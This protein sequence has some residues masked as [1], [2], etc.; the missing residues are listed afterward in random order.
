[1]EN[2]PKITYGEMSKNHLT[3]IYNLRISY[4]D[5]E[6]ILQ[7]APADV[8][9]CH[10]QPKLHPGTIGAF[11]F[12]IN[13]ILFLP[14]GNVFDGHTIISSWEPLRRAIISLSRDKSKDPSLIDKHAAFLAIIQWDD[15]DD[16]RSKNFVKSFKDCFNTEVFNPDV[17]RKTTESDFFVGD[18]LLAETRDFIK[19][20][21]S[22]ALGA[23]FICLGDPDIL[24]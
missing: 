3:W 22:G 16:D 6:I 8:K 5:S 10:H 12:L 7:V 23:I 24:K 15:D 18:L 11:T 13:D 2:E 21:I 4:P 19:A 1:M 9:A 14:S 17:T 20:A